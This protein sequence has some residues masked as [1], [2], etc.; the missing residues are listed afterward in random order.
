MR[1]LLNI[2]VKM[3]KSVVVDEIATHFIKE[4]KETV[5]LC[6]PEEAPV[7]TARKLAGK[8]SDSI[9]DDPNIEFDE[10]A[11]AEGSAIIGD[12]AIIYDSY[13]KTEWEDVISAMRHAAV[14]HNCKRAF[15][16]PITCFTVGMSGG[17]RNDRLVEIATEAAALAK[18]LDMT[19]FIFCHLNPPSAGPSHEQGG[20]VQSVQF[21]GSR[22]MM[23]ACHAMIGLEG[24][25]SADLPEQ[26]RNRRDLVLLEDRN[27][28]ETGRIN[29]WYNRDTGRLKELT[30]EMS[31]DGQE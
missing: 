31:V 27:F 3:G 1:N 11:F 23:R 15:I 10:Q 12:N 22:A 19:I 13:Q 4:H 6:K 20:K 9:F 21:A 28:G 2:K 24:N 25:K 7:V 30:K 18:E 16:D 14:A 26:E 29:L 8:A 17:E 5:F